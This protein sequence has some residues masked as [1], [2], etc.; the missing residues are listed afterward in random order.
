[1]FLKNNLNYIKINYYTF[2]RRFNRS[3]ISSSLRA[4][5]ISKRETSENKDFVYRFHVFKRIHKSFTFKLSRLL[6]NF[7]FY[8]FI[9]Y[10]TFDKILNY[11]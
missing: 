4:F 2:T 1:M 8:Y 7:S 6:K 11:I 5:S 3:S 9:K 10:F